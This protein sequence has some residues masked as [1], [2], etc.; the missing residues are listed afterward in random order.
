MRGIQLAVIPAS[1]LS[2]C[3]CSETGLKGD[4]D[5]SGIMCFE[6]ADGQTITTEDDLDAEA[7]GIQIRVRCEVTGS[8]SCSVAM[9]T[10]TA[11]SGASRE[12]AVPADGLDVVEFSPVTIHSEIY[13]IQVVC[14]DGEVESNV[15]HIEGWE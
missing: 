1:L 11:G 12:Y 7:P 4:A 5:Y 2:G 15:I 10:I 14:N 3:G 13:T 6:P 9:M 8:Y